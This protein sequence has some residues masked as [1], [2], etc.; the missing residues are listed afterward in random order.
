[1]TLRIESGKM[2]RWKDGKIESR[3]MERGKDEKME[4]W[5]TGKMERLKDG[6]MESTEAVKSE[7]MLG[8]KLILYYVN[9]VNQ[10][11]MLLLH[12]KPKDNYKR[13]A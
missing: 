2:K 3:K 5:K 12:C 7:T 8:R 1:M 10:I 9:T 11:L 6:K 13:I 4:R